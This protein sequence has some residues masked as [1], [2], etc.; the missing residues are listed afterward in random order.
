MKLYTTWI[1]HMTN[2]LHIYCR[3]IDFGLSMRFSRKL[4]IFYEKCLYPF[5]SRDLKQTWNSLRK[6]YW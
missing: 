1:Q 2:P 3:L 5:V 6:G 4:G